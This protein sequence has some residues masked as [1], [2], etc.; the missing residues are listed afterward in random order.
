VKFKWVVALRRL[1]MKRIT[2]FNQVGGRIAPLSKETHYMVHAAVVW[3]LSLL[4]GA[5][6][7]AVAQRVPW[8]VSCLACDDLE[9]C[10]TAKTEDV[11]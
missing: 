7:A 2:R 5:C 8:I 9:K 4:V 1:S 10:E 6:A 11:C 3:S